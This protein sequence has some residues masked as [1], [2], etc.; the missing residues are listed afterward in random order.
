MGGIN[1][2]L[3]TVL[4]KEEF[5][6]YKTAKMK[7]QQKMAKGPAKLRQ[8]GKPDK[9]YKVNKIKAPSAIPSFFTSTEF[10]EFLLNSDLSLTSKEPVSAM[11]FG[12]AVQFVWAYI[13]KNKLQI[14][15]PGTEFKLDG[16]LSKLFSITPE[17]EVDSMKFM[18]LTPHIRKH[19]MAV[20]PRPPAAKMIMV[21]AMAVYVQ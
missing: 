4:A 11:K 12:K 10:Q 9:R 3:S 5:K 1:R 19:L 16:K 18:E 15:N 6:P 8:D 21:R 13:K 17:M 20:V 14:P 2:H 7:S